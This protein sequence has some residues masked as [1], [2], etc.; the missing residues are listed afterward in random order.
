M[1]MSNNSLRA[2]AAITLINCDQM[3]DRAKQPKANHVDA[4]DRSL[5][6]K[7]S[8]DGTYISGV[9]NLLV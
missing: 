7:T 8:E 9:I 6:T 2:A 5:A 4:V 3:H 1:Q